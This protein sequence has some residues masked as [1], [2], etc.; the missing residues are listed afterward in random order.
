MEEMNVRDISLVGSDAQKQ[1]FCRAWPSVKSGLEMLAALV[2]NPI[3]QGAIRL[4]IAAGNAVAGS[5]CG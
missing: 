5:I 1:G 4:V 3:A 2:K